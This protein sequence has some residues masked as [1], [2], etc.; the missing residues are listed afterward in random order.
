MGREIRLQAFPENWPL[1]TRVRTGKTSGDFIQTAKIYLSWLRGKHRQTPAETYFAQETD[2]EYLAICHETL[3]LVTTQP[4]ILWRGADLD[5]R[6]EVLHF[7]LCESTDSLETRD[8]FT[9]AI[10]GREPIHPDATAT[11]GAPIKW[12]DADTTRRIQ[13]VLDEIEYAD[14]AIHFGTEK[15]LREP[16]YKK[17]TDRREPIGLYSFYCEMKEYYRSAARFGNAT[18]VILD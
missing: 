16:L 14:V 15:F 1:L 11:Q 12:N 17:S 9:Y 6:F 7:L 8:A 2:E 4:Q 13:K 3:E 18:I 5:R 10:Y